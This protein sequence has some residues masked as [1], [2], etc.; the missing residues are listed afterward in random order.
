[1]IARVVVTAALL[2]LVP[3]WLDAQ[4]G[5]KS[6]DVARLFL[7]KWGPGN[8]RV[9]PK[10]GWTAPVPHEFSPGT[11]VLLRAEPDARSRF[12]RWTGDVPEGRDPTQANL[13]IIATGEL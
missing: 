3:A 5:V 13:E 11:R 2:C 12:S 8:G 10:A 6:T 9:F 1:M 4:S 7:T